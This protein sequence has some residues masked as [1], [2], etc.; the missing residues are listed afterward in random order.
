LTGADDRARIALMRTAT[1]TD[2][3]NGLSALLDR[4]R[5]GETVL[6]LDRGVPVARLEPVSSGLSASGRL[7]RL[8]RAGLVRRAV[9]PLSTDILTRPRP[10][11]AHGGSVVQALLEERRDGR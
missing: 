1:I 7:E 4:V 9:R 2:A 5:A 8:E 3:K 6:I 10:M 11:P